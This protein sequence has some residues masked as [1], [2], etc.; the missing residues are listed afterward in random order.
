MADQD[1]TLEDIAEDDVEMVGAEEDAPPD[2]D[3]EGEGEGEGDN[4]TNLP[5]IEPEV[6]VKV[7]F[8]EYEAP[9]ASRVAPIA[10]LELIRLL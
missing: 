2:G 6:P 7:T 1:P 9:N 3:G 8:L 5:E 4:E 10:R